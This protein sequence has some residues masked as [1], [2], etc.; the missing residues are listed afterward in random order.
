MDDKEPAGEEQRM[1]HG[2]DQEEAP[3]YSPAFARMIIETSHDTFTEMDPD[4][5]IM[6]LEQMLQNA[7]AK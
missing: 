3:E 7:R 1:A 2:D 6:L 4:A 5:L